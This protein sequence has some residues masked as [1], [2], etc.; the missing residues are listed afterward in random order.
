VEWVR[1]LEPLAFISTDR[2]TP[3]LTVNPAAFILKTNFEEGP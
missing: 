2:H 1:G 3:P